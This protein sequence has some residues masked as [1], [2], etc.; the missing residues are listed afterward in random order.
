M[1]KF[2]PL[3]FLVGFAV[4]CGIHSM[5][6]KLDDETQKSIDI[7]C[8]CKNIFPDEAQCQ[9][10][11]SSFFDVLDRDC[12]EDALA[13]DKGASKETLDCMLDRTRE[14]NDCLK[15]KLDCNDPNSASL[16]TPN[17]EGCPELPTAVQTALQGCS[18]SSN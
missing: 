8:S 2:A 11:F 6:N 15:S 4:G 10:Q 7:A 5:L 14:Y 1:R 9:A 12:V 3:T 16:C 17:Y 13:E 18:N